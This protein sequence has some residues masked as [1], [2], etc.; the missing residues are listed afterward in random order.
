[1]LKNFRKHFSEIKE[2]FNSM[3]LNDNEVK[4][5]TRKD[6][7]NLIRVVDAA[8]DCCEFEIELD[9]QTGIFLL[10][11]QSFDDMKV[12]D[13]DGK[14]PESVVITYS[15]NLSKTDYTVPIRNISGV[16]CSLNFVNQGEE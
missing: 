14:N 13:M 10:D 4:R 12:L 16:Y 11:S 15:D 1:M 5:V 9:F 8:K 2:N 7:E 6:I 3:E